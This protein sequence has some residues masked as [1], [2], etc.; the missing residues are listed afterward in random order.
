MTHQFTTTIEL[1]GKTATGFEVP[2][3]VVE[4]LGAGKKPRVKVTVGEHTYRSTVAVYG[5]RFMVPLNAGNRAAAGVEAGEKVEVE[6]ELDTAERTV[7][8]PDTLAA[9]L[10]RHPGAR[11]AFD[12]L[13]YSKQRER[14]FAVESAKREETR[15]RRILK[16]L[17][18]LV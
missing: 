9:A 10:E 12:A 11:A 18:E 14:V 13:S 7:E 16:I 2:A 4:A 17:E 15:E 1:G 5:A 8:I 6:V 3:E